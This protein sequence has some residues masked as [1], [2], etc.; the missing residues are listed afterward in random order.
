MSS[1]IVLHAPPFFTSTSTIAMYV[2]QPHGGTD[3]HRT[4]ADPP[5]N[6]SHCVNSNPF[7]RNSTL[8]FKTRVFPFP[9]FFKV[10]RMTLPILPHLSRYGSNILY[11]AIVS[12]W[13]GGL[14]RGS[15]C[16]SP[17]QQVQFPSFY[18]LELGDTHCCK[19]LFIE[20]NPPVFHVE[21]ICAFN[22]TCC[23]VVREGPSPH[24]EY[25]FWIPG[26]LEACV[27][28]CLRVVPSLPF[29]LFCF[30]FS[31]SFYLLILLCFAF[32]FALGVCM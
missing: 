22:G 14:R 32:A 9:F 13:V 30:H 7:P 15:L 5:S 11:P 18:Q 12:I 3:A 8:S 19:L 27:L 21:C 29:P 24:I 17:R 6:T 2:L 23:H 10:W 26:Y 20:W 25:V 4:M 1:F 28:A 31:L 16:V